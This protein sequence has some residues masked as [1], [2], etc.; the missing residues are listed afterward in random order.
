LAKS[1]IPK[2]EVSGFSVQC[3]GFSFFAL[4]PDT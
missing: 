4:I 3:S 1:T 2:T